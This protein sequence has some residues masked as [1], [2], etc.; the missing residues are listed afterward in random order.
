MPGVGVRQDA[1]AAIEHAVERRDETLVGEPL[2]PAVHRRQH[3]PRLLGVPHDLCEGDPRHDGD[4]AGGDAVAA[5]V[6][7]QNA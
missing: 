6:R 2:Q 4:H 1:G 5:G 7:D 3:L